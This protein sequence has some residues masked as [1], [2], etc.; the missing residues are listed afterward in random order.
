[1]GNLD[2][3]GDKELTNATLFKV[4]LKENEVKIVFTVFAFLAIGLTS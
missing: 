4:S 2:H 3:E 1:M